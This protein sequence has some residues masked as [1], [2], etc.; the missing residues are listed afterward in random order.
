M[1]CSTKDPPHNENFCCPE[2]KESLFMITVS[3]VSHQKGGS[4]IMGEVGMFYG[5]TQLKNSTVLLLDKK[6]MC[7]NPVFYY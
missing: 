7:S 3:V 2:R 1:G 4:G 6:T 5:I